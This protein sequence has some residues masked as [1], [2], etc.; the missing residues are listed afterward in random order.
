M[1]PTT[2]A[3]ALAAL[4]LAASLTA[5]GS[6]SHGDAGSSRGAGGPA[7]AS[8]AGGGR[9]STG[10]PASNP[11]HPTSAQTA[12]VARLAQHGGPIYC[13]GTRGRAVALTFDDGPG[14]YTHLALKK[15]RAAHA[16][17]TFFLVG[18]LVGPGGDLPRRETAVAAMGDHTW[19]HPVLTELPLAAMDDQLART[20][21]TVAAATH[22]PVLFF[23]PPYGARNAAVDAEARQLGM[24]EILW[25]VDSRDSEGANYAGIARNVI[26]GLR[27]GSIILMHENRG[28]TIRALTTI[29]PELARRHLQA[30]TLPE[31]FASDPP[32]DAQLRAGAAG[33]PKISEPDPGVVPGAAGG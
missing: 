13:A 3:I 1:R 6:P 23:R 32:T 15:L 24:A 22:A 29:L 9:A 10:A 26:A 11:A 21:R 7:S 2:L 18:R 25:D 31:L 28:Q 19:T 12:A 16:R 27:P 8:A 30:V 5:C 14:P 4:A 17:A 20:Q 33:C